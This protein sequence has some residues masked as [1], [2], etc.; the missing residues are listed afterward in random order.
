[1][2]LA[3]EPHR[4]NPEENGR[5]E[6]PVPIFQHVAVPIKKDQRSCQDPLASGWPVSGFWYLYRLFLAKKRSPFK[7][8]GSV[9][10]AESVVAEPPLFGLRRA[11]DAL[12]G[13][14]IVE[15]LLWNSRRP[16][17]ESLRS[18]P[19]TIPPTDPRS[20]GP[21]D[22][23]RSCPSRR[24]RPLCPSSPHRG[25]HLQS[26]R[27]GH[28]PRRSGGPPPRDPC[29]SPRLATQLTGFGP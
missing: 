1:M 3:P 19:R 11:S 23:I 28:R 26:P 7:L 18:T 14:S 8:P 13:F 22:G 29:D 4:A 17:A 12:A 20:R 15:F 24:R 2:G 16:P 6:V 5:G 27:G 21:S 10:L 9:D 25:Q